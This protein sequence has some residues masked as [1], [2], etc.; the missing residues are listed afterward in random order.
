MDS[1]LVVPLYTS[2]VRG[3]MRRR[4]SGDWRSRGVFRPTKLEGAGRN[5]Q[6]L[7]SIPTD[8]SRAHSTE[9]ALTATRRSRIMASV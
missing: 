6:R 1:G 8:R 7:R 9:V 4:Q 3:S 5:F 2:V